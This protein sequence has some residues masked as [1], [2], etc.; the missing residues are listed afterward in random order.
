MED[1]ERWLNSAVNLRTYRRITAFGI[2]L[3]GIRFLVML[4]RHF[5]IFNVLFETVEH[6]K[7]DVIYFFVVMTP[8]SH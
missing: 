6:A 4:K 2:I 3:M 5:P 7:N 8:N 1:F